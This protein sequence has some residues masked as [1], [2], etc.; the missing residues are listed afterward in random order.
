MKKLILILSAATMLAQNPPAARPPSVPAT[1]ET[2]PKPELFRDPLRK[3]KNANGEI[4]TANLQPLFS[5]FRTRRGERPMKPWGRFILT[6]VQDTP[7]GVVV[8]NSLD[9]K[10]FFLRNYPY[11]VPVNTVIHAFA[12]EDGYQNY[13]DAAGT[14]HSVHAYDYGIPVTA[15]SA[16]K[17]APK[18]ASSST[19]PTNATPQPSSK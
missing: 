15:S 7:E 4:V 12:V 14:E 11:K 13:K 18:Q 6:T 8:S 10:V 16:Q 2:A 1:P 19:K 3:V 17:P 5:W 9:G